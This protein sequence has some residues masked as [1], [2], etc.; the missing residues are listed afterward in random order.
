MPRGALAEIRADGEGARVLRRLPDQRRH[1]AVRA[2]TRVRDRDEPGRD[3]VVAERCRRTWLVA[4][5]R[6]RADRSGGSSP[7][8]AAAPTA[9]A[10][11]ASAAAASARSSARAAS[12]SAA[13]TDGA[14]RR[15]ASASSCRSPH[16]SAQARPDTSSSASLTRRAASSDG[17]TAAS[18]PPIG[19]ARSASPTRRAFS[20]SASAPRWRRSP[21]DASARGAGRARHSLPG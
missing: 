4:G 6:A 16:S 8:G 18:A 1:E 7:R 9:D 10:R 13:P 14:L 17:C 3:A 11:A 15:G 19:A 12:T 20:Q 2:A 5:C 21:R